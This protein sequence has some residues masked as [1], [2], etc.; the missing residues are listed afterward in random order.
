MNG[1][2]EV[3][4]QKAGRS[5]ALKRAASV[6]RNLQQISKAQGSDAKVG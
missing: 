2:P 4:K 1:Y 3:K 6:A 5:F